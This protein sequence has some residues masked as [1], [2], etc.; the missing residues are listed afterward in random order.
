MLLSKKLKPGQ[1]ETKRLVSQYSQSLLNA[2]YRYDLEQRKRFKTIELIIEE[3]FWQPPAKPISGDEIVGIQVGVNE[4]ELQRKVKAAGGKWNY[5]RKVWEIRYGEVVRLGLMDRLTQE[6]VSDNG[7]QADL[8][9]IRNLFPLSE[10][11]K[12]V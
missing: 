4:V 11:P 8:S 1:P 7:K 6:K 12:T 2:R 10:R 9:T 3:S 5:N